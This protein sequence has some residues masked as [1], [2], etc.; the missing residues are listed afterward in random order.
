VTDTLTPT[1]KGSITNLAAGATDSTSMLATIDTTKAGLF[2]GSTVVQQASNGATTSGL[3]ITKLADQNVG[4][5][6]S[7]TGGVF[8]LASPQINNPPPGS[9]AIAFGNVRIGSSVP[10]QAISVS[11]AASGPSG[12]VEALDANVILPPPAGITASGSFSGLAPGATDNSSLLVGLDTSTAG[13][14]GGNLG[15]S[16]PTARV[17]PATAR[18]RTWGAR[19]SPSAAAS[20]GWPTRR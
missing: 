1:F 3:G 13:A 17:C 5:S 12:L 9:P 10:N 20:I 4:V 16:F 6:G 19:T 15:V 11:N 18:R 14:H 2:N 7:V 8:V